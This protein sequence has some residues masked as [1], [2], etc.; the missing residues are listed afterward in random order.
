MWRIFQKYMKCRFL[1]YEFET[2]SEKN[3][4]TIYLCQVYVQLILYNIEQDYVA[5]LPENI[6]TLYLMS[7]VYNAP[8]L[9]LITL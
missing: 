1:S 8:T 7:S 9:Q 4:Y 3:K 5:N 6:I 2:I